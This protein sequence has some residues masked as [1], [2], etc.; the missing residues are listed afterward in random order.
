MET[1]GMGNDRGEV[2]L[3]YVE[4]D[5]ETRMVLEKLLRRKYPDL[6]V[7][8]AGNGQEGLDLFHLHHPDFVITDITMPVMNGIEMSAAIKTTAPEV[9]I[10]AVTAHTNG[11]YL[12][13][14]KDLGITQYLMKPIQF[15]ELFAAVEGALREIASR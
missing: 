12:S 4:D 9:I 13:Q 5:P 15:K 11:E 8:A 3:L 7:F 6:Q 10:I 1:A 14:A 2:K